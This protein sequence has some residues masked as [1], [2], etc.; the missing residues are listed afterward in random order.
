[1]TGKEK[2]KLLKE[3]RIQVAKENGIDF[4]AVECK[5]KGDCKGT[6]PRCEME[7]E[8]L[9]SCIDEIVHSGG[10]VIIP[11]VYYRYMVEWN[12]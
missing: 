2:C 1:M 10:K 9:D 4:F 12:K 7:I 5:Q 6:C 11:D 3:I 8:Y